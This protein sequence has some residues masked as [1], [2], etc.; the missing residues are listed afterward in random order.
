[1]SP[2]RCRCELHLIWPSIFIWLPSS[3]SLGRLVDS[4]RHSFPNR[5]P[6]T[7]ALHSQLQV[8]VHG[9]C[10]VCVCGHYRALSVS[11]LSSIRAKSNYPSEGSQLNHWSNTILITVLL[12]TV[13]VMVGARATATISSPKVLLHPI[14]GGTESYGHCH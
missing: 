5:F 10:I 3:I 7:T 12:A 4:P 14:H 6:A 2:L 13:V 8:R 11:R 1:M 9:V